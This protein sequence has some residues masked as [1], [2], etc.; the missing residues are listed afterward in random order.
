MTCADCKD[1]P[2]LEALQTLKRE[3][4]WQD[5]PH[6]KTSI[7]KTEG[8]NHMACTVCGAHICWVCLQAFEDANTCYLHLTAVHGGIGLLHHDEIIDEFLD[9]D[10]DAALDEFGNVMEAW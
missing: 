7:E 5:C 9:F 10:Q 2:N 4:G 6:C 8:C 1:S 3:M